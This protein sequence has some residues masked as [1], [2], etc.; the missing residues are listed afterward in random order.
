MI[1]KS[2]KSLKILLKSIKRVLRLFSKNF[3]FCDFLNRAVKFTLLYLLFLT[4]L[5]ILFTN[6]PEPGKLTYLPVKN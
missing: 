5:L 4:L 6:S 3:I 2:L 1:V